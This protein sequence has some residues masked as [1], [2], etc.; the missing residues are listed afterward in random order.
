MYQ[1]Y[2]NTL[3]LPA[4]A[5][6]EDLDIM[7]ESNYKYLCSTGK[8]NKVV[9]ARGLGNIARIDFDS[10]PDRFKV[11]IVKKLGYAP[12]KNT[13]NLILNHY[14]DDYEAQDFYANYLLDDY[15]TLPAATQQEYTSCE[16]L[17]FFSIFGIQNNVLRC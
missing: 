4:R 2:Q 5:L 9:T 17:S 8:I 16:L 1:F 3:T 14:N 6:Y 13:Q 7:S 12:K 10:I 15:R 11:Q